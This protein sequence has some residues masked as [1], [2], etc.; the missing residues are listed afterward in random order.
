MMMMIRPERSRIVYHFGRTIFNQ[1]VFASHEGK[2]SCS[3]VDLAAAGNFSEKM[4]DPIF[5]HL[6]L[7]SDNTVNIS[8]TTHRSLVIVCFRQRQSN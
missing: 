4:H 3:L 1:R 6:R 7:Q 5:A 2:I 8:L